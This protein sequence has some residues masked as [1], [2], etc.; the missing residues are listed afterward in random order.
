MSERPAQSNVRWIICGLLLFSTTI[1][2]VD[3]QV[4]SFLKEY[5]CLPKAQGGFGWSG[6][7]FSYLT[8]AFTGVYALMTVAAGWLIDRIG[9]RIGLAMSLATWSFFGAMNAFVG[10]LL[11]MHILVRSAFAVGEAGN[12]PASIKTV[13]EWFPKKERALATGIFNAGANVGAMLAALFVPW[14]LGHYGYAQGWKIAFFVTGAAGVVW[15]IPWFIFYE[16]PARHRRLSAAEFDYIHAESDLPISSAGAPGAPGRKVAWSR[17]FSLRQTWAFAV[18]KFLT[19]GIWWFYLFWFPDYLNKQFGM[20][21]EQVA[22]PTFLVYAIS[23]IG[24]V[25][26]GR[27]PMTLMNRGMASHQARMAAMFM[28]ALAPLVMLSTQYFGDV[29]HFGVSWAPI[30]AVSTVCI[31]AS[32]H[33]AWSANLF[34]TVSD[35]FPK[36]A[37]GSVTGIGTLVGG[38]GG[39][40]EQLLPGRLTDHFA[41]HPNVA[42]GIMFGIC[43]FSYLAAWGLIKVLVPRPMPVV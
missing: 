31:A 15:L 12:F 20:T 17:L 33:Q 30:L 6:Q 32:A 23:I 28:I 42:Y 8:S 26:G 19:D 37:V 27:L 21:K 9:T 38:V 1:N 5:Y 18:G 2:Y 10:R 35:M 7:D 29:S 13:A 22:L 25:Y 14:C 3:R 43:A 39:V 36:S 41:A 34:T 24:S 4:I 40:I 11:P 16:V